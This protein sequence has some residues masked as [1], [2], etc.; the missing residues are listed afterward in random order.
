ML[1]LGR[2]TARPEPE[3]YSGRMGTVSQFLTGHL[4]FPPGR[5]HFPP[6][7]CLICFKH[8]ASK[9]FTLFVGIELYCTVL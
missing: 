6:T 1:S 7:H 4:F 5:C 2:Q 9:R 8:C 3:T